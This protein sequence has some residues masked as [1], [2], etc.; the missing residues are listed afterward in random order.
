MCCRS[1]RVVFPPLPVN[2][3]SERQPF[4][5][6]MRT[7]GEQT[8]VF[9]QAALT[10]TIHHM[11]LSPRLTWSMAPHSTFPLRLRFFS[12]CTQDMGFLQVNGV[13]HSSKSQMI[14]EE[15]P[16]TRAPNKNS[17]ILTRVVLVLWWTEIVLHQPDRK[18]GKC[19]SIKLL[20]AQ[21]S[22]PLA[23]SKQLNFSR[24]CP[25]DFFLTSRP[26]L[27][28]V[29]HAHRFKMKWRWWTKRLS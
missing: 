23:D 18:E 27:L 6:P 7:A 19:A 26:R 13:Q 2:L 28:E 9:N 10:G 16:V 4:V 14:R 20:W 5:I 24:G 3:I 12:L 1:S 15:Q 29:C 17:S 11:S 25:V 21:G 22:V 8:D